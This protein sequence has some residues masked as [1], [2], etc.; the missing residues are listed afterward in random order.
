MKTTHGCPCVCA[1]VFELV[2]VFA[3]VLVSTCV[4]WRR[5]EGAAPGETKGRGRKR[6]EQPRGAGCRRTSH[7]RHRSRSHGAPPRIWR[8][9]RHI[10]ARLAGSRGSSV[11]QAGI[12]QAGCH[13]EE[14]LR[15][16]WNGHTFPRRCKAGR[17]ICSRLSKGHET[18]F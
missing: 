11:N 17:C 18:T 7:S 15:L 1:C 2:C 16:P 9:M 10:A 13:G 14:A 3:C 6:G 5:N 8:T 12:K 4:P